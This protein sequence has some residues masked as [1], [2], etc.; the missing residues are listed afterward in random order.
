M[1]KESMGKSQEIE[2]LRQKL[3]AEEDRHNESRKEASKLKTKVRIIP[4]V[5]L[6]PSHRLPLL[7]L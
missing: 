2:T 4:K 1:E 7:L 6:I 5:P 3:C